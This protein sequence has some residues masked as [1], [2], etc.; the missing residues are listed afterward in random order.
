M[1]PSGTGPSPVSRS[2]V[3]GTP[4]R[5]A[6][7][8]LPQPGQRRAGA[9]L[10]TVSPFRS[11]RVPAVRGDEAWASA[12]LTIGVPLAVPY[13]AVA[14]LGGSLVRIIYPAYVLL[15]AGLLIAKRRPLYPAFVV[16]VFAFSPFIRRVAD[17]QAG[18]VVFNPILL[19]PYVGLLPTLPTLLRKALGGGG[20]AQY[21]PFGLIL[22]CVVYASFIAMFHMA[23]VP[24]IYEAMRW[25]LPTALCVFI[26]AKP[27]EAEAV[28]AAVIRA[29][30]FVVPVL[31]VY[32]ILQFTVAP[33]WDV[34]WMMNI[35]NA[36]FGLPEASKIRVFSMMNSP[37]T[38][39]VFCSYA[40][41]F[42]AGE[43]LGPLALAGGGLPLLGLTLIRTAWLSTAAG[44]AVLFMRATGGRRLV[45]FAGTAA[46]ALAVGV[47]FDSPAIPPDIRNLLADRIDTFSSIGT[48][49][50]TYDRLAVYEAF[51]ERLADSLWGEGF[52]ANASTASSTLSS[53]RDLVS[54]DSGLLETYLIFGVIGGTIYF[55]ALASLVVKASR[56]LNVGGRSDGAYAVLWA[57]I[58]ILPL[59]S[60]HVAEVGVLVWTVLGILFARAEHMRSRV[61]GTAGRAAAPLVRVWRQKRSFG[62]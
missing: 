7:L 33:Q 30:C 16:A 57:A 18:F 50:S 26:M 31:T 12:L 37:G 48:D 43:G 27:E 56:L 40:M 52:G 36:T 55:A 46:L 47:A 9:G 10:S 24:A 4:F 53:R 38:A 21:W 6:A 14:A 17:Y 44:L 51:A 23:F 25:L 19:A 35:D 61:G 28:H 62:I 42:L 8:P 45:L 29:L 20:S 15:A 2:R 49:T 13:V 5:P 3:P 58:S 22:A 11:R 41:V 39:G 59:G 1:V 60:N 54:I 34:Y 32:G